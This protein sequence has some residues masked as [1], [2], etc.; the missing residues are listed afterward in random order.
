MSCYLF[1]CFFFFF[2]SRRRHTR[3]SRDWSSDVCSS[4]L[5]PPEDALGGSRLRGGAGGGSGLVASFRLRWNSLIPRPSDDPISGIR[6]APNT[7]T[8]TSS[9]IRMWLNDRSPNIRASFSKDRSS[10]E[11]RD[12]HTHDGQQRHVE[13]DRAERDRNHEQVEMHRPE[14]RRHGRSE[15]LLGR[16]LRKKPPQQRVEQPAQDE[17]AGEESD[18]K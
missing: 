9:R 18:V 17:P 12:R 11:V 3:C 14:G 16:A 10:D 5:S 4:D 7:S 6:F 1:V 13:P 2:S 8:S 15:E